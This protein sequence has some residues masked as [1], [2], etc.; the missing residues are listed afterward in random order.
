[1]LASQKGEETHKQNT[2][3]FFFELVFFAAKIN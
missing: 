1:M 3:V 2:A